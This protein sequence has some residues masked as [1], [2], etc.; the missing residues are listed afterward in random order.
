MALTELQA[1]ELIK[2]K[3]K[4]KVFAEPKGSDA[5]W[6]DF[7]ITWNDIHV[8]VEHKQE[9]NAQM[10]GLSSWEYDGNTFKSNVQKDEAQKI[11]R[12]MQRNPTLKKSAQELLNIAK[13]LLNR[14]IGIQLK[15]TTF[16]S[17]P[18]LIQQ[19][20]KEIEGKKVLGN[21]NSASAGKLIKEI[22]TNKFK[23]NLQNGNKHIALIMIDNEVW[24]LD[25]IGVTE[26]EI[27]E[28]AQTLKTKTT[29][30][31]PR[32]NIRTAY[33]QA[34]I[35]PRNNGRIDTRALINLPNKS[36]ISFNGLKIY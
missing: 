21:I 19:F 31:I 1:F 8:Y 35:S 30:K 23:S 33:I 4:G 25:S 22:Y 10:S 20:D 2:S 9:W 36:A 17:K 29:N 18:S 16:S 13:K 3:L 11:I 5:G 26:K 6:P 7:G 34:R 27:K 14:K 28:L 24:L 12:L 15:G 32:F